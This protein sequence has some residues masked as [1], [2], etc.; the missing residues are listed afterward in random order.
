VLR[1]QFRG[2]GHLAT[3]SLIGAEKVELQVLS[4]HKLKPGDGVGL[5]IDLGQIRWFENSRHPHP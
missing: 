4:R 1:S 5:T 3:V 2:D